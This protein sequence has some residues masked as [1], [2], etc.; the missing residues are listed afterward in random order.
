MQ[1]KIL[2]EAKLRRLA[3][4]TGR[5][6]G[7]VDRHHPELAEARLDVASLGVEFLAL[8]AAARLVRLPA[9]VKSDA[10]IAFLLGKAV[11]RR[12]PL[13]RVQRRVQIRLLALDL[14]QA[15]DVGAL[16]GEPAEQALL[17]RRTDAV[18]V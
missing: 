6:G 8:E 1:Q 18:D 15:D 2:Q 7:Q 10:A 12:V 14:L 17:R 9:A 11:A 16:R 13:Q 5:A 3:V 4:R